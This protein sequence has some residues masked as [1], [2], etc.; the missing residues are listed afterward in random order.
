MSP[1]FSTSSANHLLPPPELH[2]FPLFSLSQQPW[3]SPIQPPPPDSAAAL[4]DHCKDGTAPGDRPLDPSG[5]GGAAL[6][7]GRWRCSS[8]SEVVRDRGIQHERQQRERRQGEQTMA[9]GAAAGAKEEGVEREDPRGGGWP[10]TPIHLLAARST[11]G[12]A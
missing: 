6:G 8:Q 12:V 1:Y 10:L 9:G 3:P 7:Q 5:G 11:S 2:L 4:G